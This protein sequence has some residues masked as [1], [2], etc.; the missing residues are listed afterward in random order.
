MQSKKISFTILHVIALALGLHVNAYA[1]LFGSAGDSWKEEVLLHDGS[2]L[3]VE[4]SVTRGGR[5]EIGQSPPISE[6]SLTFTVPGTNEQIVWKDESSKDVGNA[7]FLP[8]QLDALNSQTYLTTTPAGCLSYNKWNRPNPPYVI[9][10]Y[11]NKEWKRIALEELPSEFKVPNLII[12]SPDTTVEKTG[13]RFISAEMIRKIN[14]SAKQ[15]EFKTIVR[16]PLSKE[17]I[18]QMCMEMVPYKGSW[19]MP[20]DQIG[21]RFI[22]SQQK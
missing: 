5:H 12:S 13:Q 16:E 17:R 8:I 14:S 7:N 15:P 22:D 2:K 3:I 10:Q 4:R 21:R 9:F 6:Q 18:N 20:N 19:V 1:G 11:K